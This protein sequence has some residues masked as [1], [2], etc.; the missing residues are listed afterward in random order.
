M[1]G[2]MSPIS[3]RKM[4][5]PSA[6]AKRPILSCTAPVKAPLTCPNSSLSSRFS[7]RAAQFTLTRGPVML[8]L[9]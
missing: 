7:A 9:E 2:E 4:V 8:E 6:A 3:S 5:P 1:L